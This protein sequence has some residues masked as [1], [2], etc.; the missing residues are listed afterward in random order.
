MPEYQS[1]P[2]AE[3]IDYLKK[4]VNIPTKHWDDLWKGMHSR[5]FMVA[6]AMNDDLVKD[7]HDALDKALREGTTA[8]DFQKNF[9]DLVQK[10]GWT[11]HGTPGWRSDLIYNTNLGQA[12]N[13]G[14]WKQMTDPDVLRLRPYL[15]YMHGDSIKP[16]PEHV[17]WHGLTLPADDPWWDTHYPQNGWGC[18]C[19]VVSTSERDLESMGK[20]APDTA[21]PIEYYDWKDRKGLIHQVPV[22]IDPGFDYNP[23]KMA[24]DYLPGINA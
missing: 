19:Y 11:Y 3:A 23:G 20:S 12:Y 13:A 10:Y 18:H 7:F 22:G 16:R 24:Y 8:Q 21:P 1:L 5:G 9:D 4:K 15:T 17:A 14:R 6:G 2:F